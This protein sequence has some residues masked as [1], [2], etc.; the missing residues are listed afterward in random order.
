MLGLQLLILISSI[1][2]IY[3]S[4]R[5]YDL[6]S[7]LILSNVTVL[8]KLWVPSYYDSGMV[9]QREP[10]NAVVHGKSHPGS[11]VVVEFSYGNELVFTV[12]TRVDESGRWIAELPPQK[13]GGSGI[14]K[15][16]NVHSGEEMTMK[17]VLFG[18]VVF[19]SVI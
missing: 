7:N 12:K 1:I 9:L 3:A 14:L 13:A 19:C 18:D 6:E 8:E 4:V 11:Q 2:A 10:Q 15:V 17:D 5:D 16:R